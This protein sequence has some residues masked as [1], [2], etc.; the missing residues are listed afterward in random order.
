MSQPLR[1]ATYARYSSDLQSSASIE[2]QQRIC[3]RLIADRGWELAQ[4][5]SDA[6]ISGASLL[7]SGFQQ[8]QEDA[9]HGLIDVVVAEGL[10]RISRDME[11]IAAF[12]KQ[13]QFLGIPIVT[14]SE[15][16]ISE[17]HVGIKGMM[18][19]L[20]LK[21][22]AQKTHRG[23]EG[24]IKKG[25]SAGGICYGYEVVRAFHE[26]G[27][28]VTGEREINSEQAA[29]IERIFREYDAGHSARMIA[30]GLNADGIPTESGKGTGTW[31]PSTIMGNWK[32]GT[33]ILNNELYIGHLVWNR[34]KY[35]KNPQNQKRVG[36]LNVAAKVDTVLVPELQIIDLALWDRVKARQ[37][38]IRDAMNPAGVKNGAT[39]PENARRPGYL[40]SGLLKCSCCGAGYTLINKTRYGCAGARNKGAAI[41]TNRATIEREVV[42]DR[43]LTGLRDSLLHPKLISTFI[44]EYRLAFN[45]TAA[46]ADAERAKAR[47]DVAQIDKK[48]KGI[49]AAIED[50]LYQPSM[51]DRMDQLEREKL[52]V[53]RFLETTPEP[54]ALRLHPSLS[55]L[56]RSKIGKLSESLNE[57]GL[58]R[59][60]TEVLRGLISEVRME[61]CAKVGDA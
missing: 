35:H 39:R 48:I 38:A 51:K 4:Q 17:L 37:A 21:D 3:L 10:D 41:C 52:T 61:I 31:G 5:Y 6:A 40:F 49:M 15:G 55:D 44:E 8:L 12:Y 24:R 47:R 60:A 59:E 42:E 9:R 28:I 14:V 25:K 27:S 30:A 34:Q 29:V 16:E 18:S 53:T 50:G 1:A 54:P 45:A 33:G 11:H 23:L 56:Y 22:L 32:R 2:D 36:R 43:V 13:M 46:G 26:D 57:P 20:Y 7:R 19:A 58:K